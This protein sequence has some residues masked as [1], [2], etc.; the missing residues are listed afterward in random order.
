MSKRSIQPKKRDIQKI[1]RPVPGAI[2]PD[3]ASIKKKPPR[4]VKKQDA[5]DLD[6]AESEG[7]A[8]P[9][10]ARPKKKPARVE[11]GLRQGKVGDQE[12][13]AQLSTSKRKAITKKGATPRSRSNAKS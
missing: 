5:A 4:P 12:R 9:Q 10:G 6:R 13:A 11:L 3:A 2:A 1:A 8:Q 7:M